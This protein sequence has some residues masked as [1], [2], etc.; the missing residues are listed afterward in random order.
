[1]NP[2]PMAKSP[3]ALPDLI[4]EALIIL[5]PGGLEWLVHLETPPKHF[6]PDLFFPSSPIS[7][8][9]GFGMA[10]PRS[11]PAEALPALFLLSGGLEW[12]VHL[13]TSPKHFQPDFFF[14]GVWI[15]YAGKVFA[16]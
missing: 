13:Q 10:C 2:N 6:Q 12:L 5:F 16:V 8:C 11:N 14:L 3:W 9:W 7:S 15:C 1:M 4:L